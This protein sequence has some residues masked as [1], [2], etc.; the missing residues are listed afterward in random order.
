MAEEVVVNR[1][2]DID[3]DGIPN[4]QDNDADGNGIPNYRDRDSDG[5]GRLDS[6]EGVG[7]R[8][9]DGVL[10]YLDRD[11]SQTFLPFIRK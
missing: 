2:V 10:N 4:C 11:T 1:E 3:N 5:D 7:D 6:D 9:K 8:D